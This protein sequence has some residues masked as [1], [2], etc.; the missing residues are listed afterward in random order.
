MTSGGLNL[1][2][3]SAPT[4]AAT[5]NNM[6]VYQLGHVPCEF[7]NGFGMLKSY[8]NKENRLSVNI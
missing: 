1:T 7:V 8:D 5:Y 6:S 2:S 4:R 3:D